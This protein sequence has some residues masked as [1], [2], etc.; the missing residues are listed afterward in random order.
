MTHQQMAAKVIT[1][2]EGS[3]V[4]FIPTFYIS[5]VHF[6]LQQYCEIELCAQCGSH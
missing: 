4:T 3:C 5:T 1:F 2:S 6:I